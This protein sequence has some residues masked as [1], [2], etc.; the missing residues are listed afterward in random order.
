MLRS[1]LPQH[2]TRRPRCATL[3]SLA[4]AA[5]LAVAACSGSGAPTTVSGV[6]GLAARPAPPEGP[7]AGP[8]AAPIAAPTSATEATSAGAQ[9]RTSDGQVAVVGIG[10]EA[11][12]VRTGSL[13]L[14]VKDLDGTLLQARGRIVG[15]GG[16]VSDSERTNAGDQS[17]A[18]IT[19]RIPASR[20]DEALD[21]LRGFASKVVTEQ[22]KAVEVTG[23]VLDLGAR[24]DNLRATEHALQAI[25]AQATKISDILDVQNQLTNV[26]GQIEQ[27]S[28]EKAH[29][30]DQAALGTLAVTYSLPVVAVAQ[31]SS[32]WSLSTEFDRAVAQLIQLGQGLA[33]AGV[34]LLVVG[35][36]ILFGLLLVA[37]LAIFSARRLGLGRPPVIPQGGSPAASA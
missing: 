30:S 34:W 4:A 8:T 15:L 25:M 12:I 7:I 37:A 9:S 2:P 5:L 14:E 23:Q 31:V 13:A 1:P 33:V 28:T 35:L 18:L 24:I 22:T 17:I 19:Y 29:L 27:L 3:I 10:D 20:W 16:Y 6:G 11:L 21:G 32:G 26:Q 36:P